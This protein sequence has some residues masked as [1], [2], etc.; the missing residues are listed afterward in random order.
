MGVGGAPLPGQKED[1]RSTPASRQGGLESTIASQRGLAHCQGE[2]MILVILVF[3]KSNQN[4]SIS[5][6]FKS[7]FW[8]LA[9]EVGAKV[10][11]HDNNSCVNR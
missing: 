11:P 2:N 9:C 7:I 5:H 3:S 8:Y 4:A 6:V 1:L 10:F